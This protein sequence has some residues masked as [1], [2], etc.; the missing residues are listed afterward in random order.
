MST[1]FNSESSQFF[2][3][4]P[5]FWLNHPHDPKLL[6]EVWKP[7]LVVW[8][9]GDF[10]CVLPKSLSQVRYGSGPGHLPSLCM[11]HR[12][13]EFTGPWGL[14]DLRMILHRHDT[15]DRYSNWRIYLLIFT[16]ITRFSLFLF[17][18]C[19]TQYIPQKCDQ[20][21]PIILGSRDSTRYTRRPAR[22]PLS[23][24]CEGPVVVDQDL[25][26]WRRDR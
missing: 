6:S 26:L 3:R 23:L 11:N 1:F 20:W 2:N 12:H 17:L 8:H 24:P 7:E 16:W 9:V 5:V 25:P 4:G 21:L 22:C 19:T 13:R 14:L 15:V 10:L 18:E